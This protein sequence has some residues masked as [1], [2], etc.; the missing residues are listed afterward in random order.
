MKTKIIFL[1]ASILAGIC[2]FSNATKWIVDINGGGQYTKIQSAIDVAVA[3]D[4][5]IVYPGSYPD[6][7]NVNKP[8]IVMGSGYENTTIIGTTAAI[9]RISNGGIIEWFMITSIGGDGVAFSGSGIIRNCIVKSCSW[10]GIVTTG[11]VSGIYVINCIITN[12]G[13]KG[14][15][16]NGA[17]AVITVMNTISRGNGSTGFYAAGGY[18][19]G[20]T[21]WIS[22]SDGSTGAD[23]YCSINGGQGQID[24]DPLFI[25]ST[26]YHISPSGPCSNTGIPTLQDPDGSVSDMG[27]FGGPYAP[28]YPVVYEMTTTPNGSNL[29]VQSKARANY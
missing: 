26:N 12:C 16:T 3:G 17:G 8:I 21:I 9:V 29:N 10:C 13:L 1:L 20:S 4:S 25:S 19:N 6:L 18:N 28:I 2:E 22:Y 24:T 14:L 5:V 15:Q 7:V 27:Y 11:G 23:S